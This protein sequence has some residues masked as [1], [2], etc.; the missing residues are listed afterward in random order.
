MSD[1]PHEAICTVAIWY[2]RQNC[3]GESMWRYTSLEDM[4]KPLQSVVT[5]EPN[6][7]PIVSCHIDSE[8][9]YVMTTARIRVCNEDLRS[10]IDPLERVRSDWRKFKDLDPPQIGMA[11]IT[12]KDGSSINLPYGT[13]VA[14]MAP[15]YYERFWFI[16][17]P[18][19]DKFDLRRLR[20]ENQ[21]LYA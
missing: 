4:H 5:L 8:R 3:S 2:I 1:W 6:E 20:S 11:T 9:W 15:I 21:Q 10:S 12:L 13:G 14:S 7:L 16:K 19:L 18:A 17:Y